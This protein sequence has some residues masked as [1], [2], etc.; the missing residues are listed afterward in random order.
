MM[1][2]VNRGGI[3]LDHCTSCNGTWYDRTELEALLKKNRAELDDKPKEPQQDDQT[4]GETDTSRER[5][6]SQQDRDSFF[7][8]PA[9][10]RMQQQLRASRNEKQSFYRKCPHCHVHMGRINFLQK[11]GVVV[12]ICRQHGIFLDDGEFDSLH[13]FIQSNLWL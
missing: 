11:T 4:V 13:Q 6:F 9:S 2:K 12:D 1:K 8:Q 7:R 5:L 3:V 10:G